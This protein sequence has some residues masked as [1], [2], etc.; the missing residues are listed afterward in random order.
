M[1]L[2]LVVRLSPCAVQSVLRSLISSSNTARK[3]PSPMV[4][5]TVEMPPELHSSRD[6]WEPAM[7]IMFANGVPR[8]ASTAK[9]LFHRM[10]FP[11]QT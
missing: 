10:A 8:M 7:D 9:A 4:T 2:G 3:K 5:D 1:L 6:K 11:H